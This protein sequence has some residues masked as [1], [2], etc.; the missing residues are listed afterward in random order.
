MKTAGQLSK[1]QQ[2]E[3]VTKILEQFKPVVEAALNDGIRI[4]AEETR[5][6]LAAQIAG[7]EAPINL[8][9]HKKRDKTVKGVIECPVVGCKN[10][11]IKPLHCFCQHHY[12]TLPAEKRAKLRE[13][14][15][16]RRADAKRKAAIIA[17]KT[18]KAAKDA[19]EA[20]AP[21]KEAKSA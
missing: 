5:R 6:V 15:I 12:N 19:K 4:G 11:G 8:D 21:A 13:Q 7:L 20:E 9:Q 2:D 3:I 14:Q 16:Q 18:A 1:K 10:P 17:I